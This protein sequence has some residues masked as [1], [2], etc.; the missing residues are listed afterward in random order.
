MASWRSKETKVNVLKAV[1]TYKQ[2]TLFDTETTGLDANKDR[3][4]EVAAIKY[5]IGDD[6]SLKEIGRLHKYIKPPFALPEKIVELTGITDEFL[7]S[8]PYEEE[9]FDEIYEFFTEMPLIIG[10]HNTP[11]DMK[12]LNALYQRIRGVNITPYFVLDTLEMSRDLV[13]PEETENHKLGTLAHLFGLD[14]GV[15]FHSAIED[16]QVTGQLFEIFLKEYLEREE[17]STSMKMKPIIMSINF[18]EGY[19]GFSRIYVQTNMGSVFY[20][21]RKKIWGEKDANIESFDMEWV[22][23]EVCR[24]TNSQ[25]IDEF[26]R[27]RGRLM[28]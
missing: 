3:I 14:E 26:A 19:K 6:Y 17:T 15:T 8:H 25:N 10:A 22:Q 1:S 28:L 4:I 16:V 24:L 5:E 23:S 20:D 18:W 9:V 13:K 21:I 2:I 11:F 7:S 27:F 12:F